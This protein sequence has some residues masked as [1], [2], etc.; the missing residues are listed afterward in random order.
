LRLEEATVLEHAQ[1]AGD[2]RTLVFD[3]PGI[4]QNA[5]PGQFV[6]VQVPGLNDSVLRRPF[7][8]MFAEPSRLSILYKVVGRGTGEMVRL[9]E[10]D[11]V[12][13]LGPLGNGFPVPAEEVLPVL[14]GGGYG[15]A[16]LRFLV[17]TLHSRGCIFLGGATARDVF[18]TEHFKDRGWHVE[19]ATEDGS[20]GKKGLVTDLLDDWLARNPG[21]STEFFACGPDGMLRAVGDRAM[22]AG[23]PAWL[24]LDKH[25]GCGIGA[26]LACVQK[27]RRGDTEEWARVCRDGPVFE[28]SEIV[29]S[30]A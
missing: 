16:P 11:A 19:V 5:K 15:A 3:A 9:S 14:I 27:V 10:G 13:L 18:F 30:N 17:D 4:T 28:A 8:I 7:S 12:S 22:A 23:R 26:C 20:A 29:W 21:S 2:Y 6:H 24:S 1:V 25:M